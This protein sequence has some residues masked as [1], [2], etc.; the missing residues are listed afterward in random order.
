MQIETTTASS[1]I[2]E[3]AQQLALLREDTTEVHI[4]EHIR[5]MV[6]TTMAHLASGGSDATT[7]NAEQWQAWALGMA[8]GI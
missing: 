1:L 8:D 3:G 2:Q 5:G 7:K 4:A 6:A